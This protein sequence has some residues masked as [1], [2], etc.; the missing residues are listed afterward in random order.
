MA[1][2][3][4][5]H[6]EEYGPLSALRICALLFIAGFGL[7]FLGIKM[8][9]S[10]TVPVFI[11]G[12]ILGQSTIW[13]ATP[14]IAV[15]A[16]NTL[17]GASVNIAI[18]VLEFT[19]AVGPVVYNVILEEFLDDDVTGTAIIFSGC[20]L[21]FIVIAMIPA[22]YDLPASYGKLDLEDSSRRT[23][24]LVACLAV[25]TVVMAYDTTESAF[26]GWIILAIFG[27]IFVCAIFLV[28]LEKYIVVSEND[29]S[30]FSKTGTAVSIEKADPNNPGYE[31]HEVL[32]DVRF[33]TLYFIW[34]VSS[35]CSLFVFYSINDMM[36]SD[37]DDDDYWR[38]NAFT[39]DVSDALITFA[40]GN[41]AVRIFVAFAG[42]FFYFKTLVSHGALWMIGFLVAQSLALLWLS[43]VDL[44]L[45][46]EI[47]APL[48]F[49]GV[50]YGAPFP[51]V[52]GSEL[53]WFGSK[54]FNLYHSVMYS[55]LI[56]GTLIIYRGIFLSIYDFYR[57]ENGGTVGCS[58]CF[59]LALEVQSA[60]CFITAGVCSALLLTTETSSKIVDDE[61]TENTTEPSD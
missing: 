13:A 33:W 32:A 21:S 48:F 20:L 47:R 31:F 45:I 42:P 26:L 55:S 16:M 46:S 58:E 53:L 10:G 36:K 61:D 12:I 34:M 8:E 4:G 40:A 49:L 25:F 18:G 22:I 52:I 30:V 38:T 24:L 41:A 1:Y 2:F 19:I 6:M 5:V 50:S 14:V 15:A 43:Y 37:T 7:I 51:L 57:D 44:S 59:T 28:I 56:A 39:A 3:A 54:N 23:S 9:S 29:L 17:P 27:A 60:L 35:S 11:G